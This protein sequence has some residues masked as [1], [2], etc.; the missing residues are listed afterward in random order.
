MKLDLRSA[1]GAASA[2]VAC[3]ATVLP[4]QALA[5]A[6]NT[7]RNDTSALNSAGQVATKSAA[8]QHCMVV[9]ATTG[10][11]ITPRKCKTIAEWEALGYEFKAVR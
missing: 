7:S 1:L 9:E 8:K 4:A 3:F 5:K 2:A 10:S 6:V 11:R